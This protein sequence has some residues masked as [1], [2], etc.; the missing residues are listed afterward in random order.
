LGALNA[1]FITLIPKKSDLETFDG[2]RLISLC[3]SI[4]KIAIKILANRLKKVL[5]QL[6]LQEQFGFPFNRQIHDVISSSQEVMHSIKV[7]M[8]H[9]M[10]LKIGI[11]K[12]Y[13]K[14]C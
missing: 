1:K 4:F 6:I 10:V 14:V 2:N 12:D 11:A 9:V 3:N 13:D 8:F 7:K 5:S